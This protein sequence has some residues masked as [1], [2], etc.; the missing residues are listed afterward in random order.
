M[1][2]YNHRMNTLLVRCIFVMSIML[3]AGGLSATTNAT[4]AAATKPASCV[5]QVT[6]S[7]YAGVD[8]FDEGD[9]NVYVKLGRRGQSSPVSL[10]SMLTDESHCRRVGDVKATG[11]KWQKIG[12]MSLAEANDVSFGIVDDKLSQNISANRPI[13]MVIPKSEEACVPKVKC[14]AII[15]GQSAYIVPLSNLA[16]ENT[17]RIVQPH[18]VAD[19][20]LVNVSYYVDSELVY[21]TEKLESFDMRY[22]LVPEQLLQR[23]A[24]YDSGQRVVYE[25]R[26]PDTFSLSFRD[27]LFQVSHRNPVAFQVG[28]WVLALAVIAITTISVFQVIVRRR[29]WREAHG[30]I[31]RDVRVLS[32]EEREL[33]L[34]RR[35]IVGVAKRVTLGLIVAT[36]VIAVIV[37]TNTYLLKISRVDGVSMRETFHTDELVWVNSVPVTWNRLN[38]LQFVPNRGDTVI[39]RAVY[40]VTD[41]A[42]DVAEKQFLIKRVIGL[43]GERIVIRDGKITIYNNEHPKGFNPDES[44]SWAK[45]MIEDTDKQTIDLR[46]GV[47]EVFV[48]GDNRPASVDSRFNGP[49]DSS[50]VLGVVIGKVWPF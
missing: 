48:S 9:Y 2:G 15:D 49:I 41:E 6:D 45:T 1:C 21:T 11:D 22:A 36:G 5:K 24:Q 30:L 29:A 50:Q 33:L 39:V 7:F 28:L 47:S 18:S 43:P 26:V 16:D 31:H 25:S 19:D 44:A 4:V 20:T 3:C 42:E 13:V 27:F 12:T 10:Y 32:S 8:S 34:A 40:G 35:R 23:V 17:L 46:L 38:N 14:T 37:A